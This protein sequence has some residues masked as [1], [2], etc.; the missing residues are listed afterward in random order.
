LIRLKNC[1]ISINLS[2]DSLINELLDS[3]SLRELELNRLDNSLI[4][5]V[6]LGIF[7]LVESTVS[8]GRFRPLSKRLFIS[9]R[10]SLYLYFLPWQPLWLLLWTI[11][12][13]AYIACRCEFQ[14]RCS[15]GVSHIHSSR[16]CVF[17]PRHIASKWRGR[18]LIIRAECR[19]DT[20]SPFIKLFLQM[21]NKII[22]LL[23]LI[24]TLFY[25]SLQLTYLPIPLL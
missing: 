23:D 8:N 9:R 7:L 5:F 11:P 3:L 19:P 1:A 24:L 16:C 15:S 6:I 21:S 17:I 2:I 25:L 22:I 10:V 12:Y 4:R 13:I 18:S 14:P 20:Y